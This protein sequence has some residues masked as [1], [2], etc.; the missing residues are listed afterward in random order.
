VRLA[1]AVADDEAG[2]GIGPSG[3]RHGV[4]I[5]TGEHGDGEEPVDHRDAALGAQDGD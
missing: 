3:I 1:V 2:E 4:Q 5:Q